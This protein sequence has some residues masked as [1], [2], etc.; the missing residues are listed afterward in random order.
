[1]ISRLFDGVCV[2]FVHFVSLLLW[3]P[4]NDHDRIS[5]KRRNKRLSLCLMMSEDECYKEFSLCD[6][7]YVFDLYLNISFRELFLTQY[8]T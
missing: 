4:Q 6:Q 1:M 7:L 2:A 5:T 8:L 3:W